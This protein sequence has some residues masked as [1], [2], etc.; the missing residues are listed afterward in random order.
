MG[1]L[2]KDARNL[3]EFEFLFG[4]RILEK[5]GG[6]GKEGGFMSIEHGVID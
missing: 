2:S 5:R 1:V 6:K 4:K 3:L